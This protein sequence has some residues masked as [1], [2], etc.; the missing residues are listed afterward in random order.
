M[1]RTIV[2]AAFPRCQAVLLRRSACAGAAG[3]NPPGARI[4]RSRPTWCVDPVSRAAALDVLAGSLRDRLVAGAGEAAAGGGVDAQASIRALVDREAALLDPADREELVA[5]VCERSFGL[6]PLEPLL[7]DPQVD[8]IMVNGTGPVWVERGGRVEPSAVAFA[9]EAEL[10]HAIE[11]I[12]APLG[13]RVDEAEPLCDARL[14][15]CIRA[16]V[17]ATGAARTRRVHDW[18]AS[19]GWG[20]VDRYSSRPGGEPSLLRL[21]VP[22][23][24]AVKRELAMS[25]PSGEP[26][27]VETLG[28][29]SA[30]SASPN[31]VRAS[32]E[33]NWSG[34]AGTRAKTVTPRRTELAAGRGSASDRHSGDT[35]SDTASRKLVESSW[36]SRGGHRA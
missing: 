21:G 30:P 10:R 17:V 28:R 23:V 29:G 1:A 27:H 8:E 35:P 6:G 31:V 2:D 22:K 12:L 34:A 16:I 3:S 15:D 20:G 14:P 24:D 4:E 36:S 33:A 32:V 19:P 13:R 18:P 9:T 5:R 11:R 26:S 7:R 25:A